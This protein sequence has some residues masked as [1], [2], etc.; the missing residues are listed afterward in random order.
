M[1]INKRISEIIA[2]GT[3][4]GYSRRLWFASSWWLFGEKG[5]NQ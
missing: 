1:D 5:E 3:E 2:Y 4:R